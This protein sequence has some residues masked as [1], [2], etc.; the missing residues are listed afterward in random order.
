LKATDVAVPAIGAAVAAG[1]AIAGRWDAAVGAGCGAV[2]A[3]GSWLLMHALGRRLVAGGTRSQ[4]VIGLL[5]TLKLVAMGALVFLAI[6]VL[7]FDGIGV[8]L[9]LSAMPAGV[10]LMAVILGPKG[11]IAGRRSEDEIATE[12]EGD[13]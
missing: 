5:M 8:L 9:G 13:A 10:I 12:V 3:S 4:L 6:R 1:L 7:G 2:I 11:T